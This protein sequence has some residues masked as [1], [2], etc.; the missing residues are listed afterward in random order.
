MVDDR[1]LTTGSAIRKKILESGAGAPTVQ[2]INTKRFM[3][4]NRSNG[5]DA[6][7]AEEFGIKAASKEEADKTAAAEQPAK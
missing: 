7:I 6:F 4:A 3:A 2:V 1:T 5:L